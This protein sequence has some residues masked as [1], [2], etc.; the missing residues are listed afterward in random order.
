MLDKNN[1][2]D[3]YLNKYKNSNH[4]IQIIIDLYLK[5]ILLF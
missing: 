2:L 4:R 5:L 3:L 1:K